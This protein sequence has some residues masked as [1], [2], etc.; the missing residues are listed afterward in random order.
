MKLHYYES[1]LNF[2]CDSLDG[3]GAAGEDTRMDT[4]VS[5]V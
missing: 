1:I 4:A 5:L 2:Y 3:R